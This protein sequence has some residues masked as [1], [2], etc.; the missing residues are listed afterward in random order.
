M[1]VENFIEFWRD[2]NPSQEQRMAQEFLRASADVEETHNELLRHLRPKA[3][4][5]AVLVV[6]ENAETVIPAFELAEKSLNDVRTDIERFLDATGGNPSL[7]A[8]G[9]EKQRLKRGLDDANFAAKTATLRAIKN[10]RAQSEAQASTTTEVLD[11]AAK[12]DRIAED[13]G[14]KLKDIETRIKQA[15]A[16]LAKY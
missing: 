7:D 6:F 2:K 11:C 14:P 16:I 12:R 1:S 4:G 10:N 15:R 3:S 9:R 5:K 13:L 8:L